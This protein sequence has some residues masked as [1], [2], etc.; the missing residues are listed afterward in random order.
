MAA[1][2]I[3]RVAA[4]AGAAVSGLLIL[5]IKVYRLTLSPWIGRDCRFEPT[6]SEYAITAVERFG[7]VR[8]GWLVARRLGR[9]HPW[10][11]AGYDPVPENPGKENAAT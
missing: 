5:L 7:P 11:G 3:R 6:C 10:G 8:G 4:V 1:G 2:L 9:C